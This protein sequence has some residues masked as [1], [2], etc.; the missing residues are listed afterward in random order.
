MYPH[1]YPV[2][3]NGSDCRQ[4][5]HYVVYRLPAIAHILFYRIT[6]QVVQQLTCLTL[7]CP[8]GP[9]YSTGEL[10]NT[11][12]NYFWFDYTHTETDRHVENNTNFHYQSKLMPDISRQTTDL[13]TTCDGLFAIQRLRRGW[14][15]KHTD[16]HP[17]QVQR[18]VLKL[19]THKCSNDISELYPTQFSDNATSTQ[20]VSEQRVCALYR[21]TQLFT[22]SNIIYLRTEKT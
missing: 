3:Q 11:P 17:L 18:D 20:F 14:R 19:F 13:V 7:G 16:R 2:E 15:L 12:Q 21:R 5:I 4:T 22:M 8:N 1:R 9:A 6:M 10:L